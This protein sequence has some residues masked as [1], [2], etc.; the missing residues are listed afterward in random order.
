MELKY[1]QVCIFI[2][3]YIVI[4][5]YI[6]GNDSSMM[7]ME[8]IGGNFKFWFEQFNIFFFYFLI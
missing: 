3:F 5:Y 1:K 4:Q 2:C 6:K 8:K 7:N